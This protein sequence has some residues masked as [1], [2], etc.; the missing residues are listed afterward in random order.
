MTFDTSVAYL[1]TP[2]SATALLVLFMV[3]NV[4]LFLLWQINDRPNLH[5]IFHPGCPKTHLPQAVC[6]LEYNL[7]MH[8]TRRTTVARWR[9]LYT[10]FASLFSSRDPDNFL[11]DQA[12]LLMMAWRLNEFPQINALWLL[13]ATSQM[14]VVSTAI[15]GLWRRYRGIRIQGM[16]ELVNC[17]FAFIGN[18][19]YNGVLWDHAFLRLVLLVYATKYL[20]VLNFAA[21]GQGNAA[22]RH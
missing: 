21:S 7:L 6:R 19:D 10:T 22:G 13:Y 17:W 12:G 3:L 20:V 4:P 1:S 16:E 8:T 5:K 2:E 14:V 11:A 15:L 18:S 9:L